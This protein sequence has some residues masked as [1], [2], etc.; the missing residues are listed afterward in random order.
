MAIKSNPESNDL[1]DIL[2]LA[3]CV[4]RALNDISSL[5]IGNFTKD[6]SF[7]LSTQ[8]RLCSKLINKSKE[9]NSKEL[10]S[11]YY[12]LGLLIGAAEAEIHACFTTGRE[13]RRESV[14]GS[15]A[16][17]QKYEVA[18]LRHLTYRYLGIYEAHVDAVLSFNEETD[19][20]IQTDTFR[21]YYAKFTKGERLWKSSAYHFT[22][23]QMIDELSRSYL[24]LK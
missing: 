16:K 14:G 15:H 24:S 1:A 6:L 4:T 10:A 8:L 23:K 20:D 2:A 7:R 18:L 3:A 12:Q 19:Q 22:P 21:R 17:Y 13:K 9:S 5:S 11:S